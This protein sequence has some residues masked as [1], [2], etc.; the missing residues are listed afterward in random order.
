[1]TNEELEL[2]LKSCK[3]GHLFDCLT[4]KQKEKGKRKGLRKAKRADRLA[5]INNWFSK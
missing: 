1:M 5:K 4:E 2:K 3:K